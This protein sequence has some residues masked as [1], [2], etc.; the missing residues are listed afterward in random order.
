MP[1]QTTSAIILS[2]TERGAANIRT[3]LCG[4]VTP[5]IRLDF[6][7]YSRDSEVKERQCAGCYDCIT[8]TEA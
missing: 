7:R 1:R 3:T 2:R 6:V 5:I 8:L 4:L